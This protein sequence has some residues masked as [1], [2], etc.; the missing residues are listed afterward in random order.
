M[1]GKYIKCGKF[2]IEIFAKNEFL[3]FEMTSKNKLLKIRGSRFKS[4]SE[5]EAIKIEFF[6]L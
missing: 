5:Q 4:I 1:G 3:D 2:N 6:S